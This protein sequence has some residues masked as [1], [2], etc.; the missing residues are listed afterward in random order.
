MQITLQRRTSSIVR[1]GNYTTLS[2]TSTIPGRS[3]VSSSA[4][5]YSLMNNSRIWHSKILKKN[6][7]CKLLVT[8]NLIKVVL[9]NYKASS[10]ASATSEMPCIWHSVYYYHSLNNCGKHSALNCLTTFTSPTIITDF[11]H[12]LEPVR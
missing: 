7:S 9:G 2:N 12:M 10:I 3:S 4:S 11:Y 8:R 6:T 5:F 1:L